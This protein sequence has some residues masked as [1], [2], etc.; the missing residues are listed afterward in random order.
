LLLRVRAALCELREAVYVPFLVRFQ[1]CEEATRL[2]ISKFHAFLDRL[3]WD[4]PPCV[5]RFEEGI[6]RFT[7]VEFTGRQ[8]R[9]LFFRSFGFDSRMFKR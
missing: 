8:L 3:G 4:S 7:F 2:F 9:R 6:V 1:P 5:K